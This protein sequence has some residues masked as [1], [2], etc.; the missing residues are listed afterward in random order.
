MKKIISIILTFILMMSATTVGY[1]G[2]CENPYLR[3]S[4]I[5]VRS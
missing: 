5:W 1:A 2:K 3:G 4:K